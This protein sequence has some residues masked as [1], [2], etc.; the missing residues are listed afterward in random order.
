MDEDTSVVRSYRERGISAQQWAAE[1]ETDGL[2][3]I[4]LELAERYFELA[5]QQEPEDL[6]R[7]PIEPRAHRLSR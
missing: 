3:S 7:F 5:E 1:A 2:R 6:L 4:W